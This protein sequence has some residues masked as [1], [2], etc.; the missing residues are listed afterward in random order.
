MTE[1]ETTATEMT[2]RCLCGAVS[3]T[4]S[5]VTTHHH[6]C[7]CAMCRR[8]GSG[9]YLGARVERIEFEGEADITVY[10]SSEWAERAF[11]AKC[12]SNL[13][14][15]FKQDGSRY[16]S[17]GTFD[18]A[19]PFVVSGEIYIDAK[20]PGYAFAGDHPRLTEAELL[21]KLGMT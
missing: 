16:V 13:Y 4:A 18:D 2:G 9:P 5:G 19:T 1:P 21:A 14:Y 7:H 12:G 11:C 8:W 17:V 20:P 3:F 6:A 15:R 10:A